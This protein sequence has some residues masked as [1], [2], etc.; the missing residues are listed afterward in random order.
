MNRNTFLASLSVALCLLLEAVGFA[1]TRLS[2]SG[3]TLLYP[4]MENWAT[5][6]ASTH[7]DIHIETLANGSG[8]G[9][10]A[11]IAGQV[12]IGASDAPLQAEQMVAPPMVNIPVAVSAQQVN[13]HVPE[14]GRN[15]SG[16]TDTS[17]R[18]SPT[19]QSRYGTILKL[20]LSIRVSLCRTIL[21]S[22]FDGRR[23]RAIPTSSPNT[24]RVRVPGGTERFTMAPESTGH[25]STQP[26]RT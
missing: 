15:R 2:E 9:I 14:L 20:R 21:L 18:A 6:Y 26:S 7:P 8:A 13:Y 16:S 24:Y 23:P 17:L 25:K 22:R 1:Q 12:Q 3:S 19:A 4:L 10:A 5:A 11:S